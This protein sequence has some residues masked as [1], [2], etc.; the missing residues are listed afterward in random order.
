MSPDLF[1]QVVVPLL[2]VKNTA[3]LAI[4][5]PQDEFNYYT[6]LMNM[7]DQFGEGLFFTIKL[8]LICAK[9]AKTG[10]ACN[11]RLNMNP[12]F[13]RTIDTLFV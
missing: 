2:G 3:L 11:H 8:G 6:E 4:S 12:H 1:F 10:E 9:C 7:K 5:T 13:S